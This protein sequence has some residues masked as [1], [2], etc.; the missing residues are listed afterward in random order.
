M[1]IVLIRERCCHEKRKGVLGKNMR[2]GLE[3]VV[4]ERLEWWRQR[5]GMMVGRGQSWVG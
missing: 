5:S 1:I 4:C 2:G 3:T